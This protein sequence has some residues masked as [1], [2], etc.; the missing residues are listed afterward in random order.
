MAEKSNP[1]GGVAA[2]LRS[3]NI[4]MVLTSHDQLGS[5]GYRTGFWLEAFATPYYLFKD[6][7]AEIALASP[8]GGQPPIDPR[9]DHPVEACESVKRFRQD[10]D[11]RALLAD[12]LRLE[13]V[14]VSDFDACFFPGGHGPMWDLADDA[15]SGALISAFHA[16]NH[17]VAL[18]SHGVAALRCA[19]DPRG[20]SLVQGRAVTAAANSED[21]AAGLLGIVP[22]SLQDELIRLGARYSKGPDGA[23]Y[24]VRDDWLITGQNPGSA[25][26]AAR[27]LLDAL[28]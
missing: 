4:L 8:S 22:F 2:N 11:A 23:S 3:M 1:S 26:E 24:V 19:C 27:A 17:P 20:A 6:A 12:T 5:T 25:G 13:Q 14:D 28:R 16:A 7:G 15:C 18:L 10:R 9:S 21:A